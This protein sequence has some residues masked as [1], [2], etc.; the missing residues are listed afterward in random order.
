MEVILL[1]VGFLHVSE[2][3]PAQVC[4]HCNTGGKF[5]VFSAWSTRNTHYIMRG[6]WN[7]LCN[8]TNQNNKDLFIDPEPYLVTLCLRNSGLAWLREEFWL[9]WNSCP[10]LNTMA[11]CLL[12]VPNGH[13]MWHLCLPMQ[14][15]WCPHFCFPFWEFSS[16]PSPVCGGR[17]LHHSPRR[18]TCLK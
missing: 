9:D 5:K 14:A 1:S 3:S 17:T 2:S 16:C 11:L 4:R 10:L 12:I 6:S 13:L 15:L 8:D 7:L 18:R